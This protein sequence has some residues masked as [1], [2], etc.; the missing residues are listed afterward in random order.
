MYVPLWLWW[1]E[2]VFSIRRY[3]YFINGDIWQQNN[4]TNVCIMFAR[5]IWMLGK[6]SLS[7]SSGIEWKYSSALP[8]YLLH[9]TAE[10]KVFLSLRHN[11]CHP[12]EHIYDAI[13][14][15]MKWK[16]G[17]FIITKYAG[18]FCIS[19]SDFFYRLFFDFPLHL[20]RWN[21]LWCV[22]W[23]SCKHYDECPTVNQ[24]FSLRKK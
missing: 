24:S 11:F 8:F 4:S 18:L 10:K 15:W 17:N 7:K 14:F 9:I 20:V 2:V 6:E 21:T 22:L 16:G 13:Y 19:F 23:K 3:V 1:W 5:L 12:Q